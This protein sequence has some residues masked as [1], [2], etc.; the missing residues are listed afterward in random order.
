MSLP[1]GRRE[2]PVPF[3]TGKKVIQASRQIERNTHTHSHTHTN[4][5]EPTHTQT[6]THT[7]TAR[8]ALL[9]RCRLAH[10]HRC[11]SNE[12]QGAHVAEDGWRSAHVAL[13]KKTLVTRRRPSQPT[14]ASERSKENN[15]HV[16]LKQ[17]SGKQSTAIEVPHSTSSSMVHTQSVT[18]LHGK[19]SLLF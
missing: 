8:V 16:T 9:A 18:E 3:P 14:C 4:T 2:T 10:V 5:N 6:N 12:Q 19:H 11:S 15:T 7:H 1:R 17:V 13:L